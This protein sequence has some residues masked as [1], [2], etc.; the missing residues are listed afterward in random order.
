LRTGRSTP[1]QTGREQNRLAKG[2]LLKCRNCNLE[3]SA[4]QKRLTYLIAYSE[5][6]VL[7]DREIEQGLPVELFVE[8]L[9]SVE[10]LLE[11]LAII[12]HTAGEQK[13]G[14]VM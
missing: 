14:E 11:L 5:L 7:N 3:R 4:C 12:R 10:P 9:P 8:M 6:S 2:H 1:K 13:G